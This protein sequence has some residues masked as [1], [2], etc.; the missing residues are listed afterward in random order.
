[1]VRCITCNVL[2]MRQ[3]C[4]FLYRLAWFDTVELKRLPCPKNE[5]YDDAVFANR[6]HYQLT[7]FGISCIDMALSTPSCSYCVCNKW[8]QNHR[9]ILP[10]FLLFAWF[11]SFELNRRRCSKNEMYDIMV[12]NDRFWYQLT[13]F[14]V[15]IFT[16]LSWLL[17]TH[18][19][20]EISI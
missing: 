8:C 11:Y 7:M 15:C 20:Y 13:M 19:A 4:R 5:M 3:F 9:S 16:G 6:F 2:H 10:N 1:M 17:D 18:I 12:F 14:E